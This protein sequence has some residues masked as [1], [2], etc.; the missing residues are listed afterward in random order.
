MAKRG[1]PSKYKPEYCE[2][3]LKHMGQG[4][5]YQS[6]AAIVDVDADTLYNW[7][8]LH[9]E[10]SDTKKR[11]F[12]KCLLRWEQIGLTGT[13]GINTK[14]NKLGAFNST[15]WI[16]NMKNRFN[17]RDKHEHVGRDG[18]QLSVTAL[19]AIESDNEE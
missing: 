15:A 8:K 9:P 12:S 5:S 16:F 10:F 3:L 1:Q 19:F 4:L 17:W 14:D 11:A 13:L 18:E 2:M 6:F 7:E